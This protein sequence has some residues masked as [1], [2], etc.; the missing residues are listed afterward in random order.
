M[1]QGPPYHGMFGPRSTTQSPFRADIGMHAGSCSPSALDSS[2]A[3]A[4]IER[5]RSSS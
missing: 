3:S 4:A 5:K 2:E 1:R